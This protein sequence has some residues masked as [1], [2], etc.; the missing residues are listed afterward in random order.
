M[1]HVGVDNRRYAADRVVDDG[2]GTDEKNRRPERY[3]HA[4]REDQRGG[5]DR[6]SGREASTDEEDA[7]Q[8]LPDRPPISQLE[9][10]VNADQLQLPEERNQ[11]CD[12]DDHGERNRELELQPGQPAAFFERHE[13]GNRDEADGA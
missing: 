5:I 2:H 7:A 11:Q 12:D 3:P 4:D 1:D 6:D 13:S 8:E 10:L 9:E